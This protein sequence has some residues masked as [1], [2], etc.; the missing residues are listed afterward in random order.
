MLPSSCTIRCFT[1]LRCVRRSGRVLL[2]Y[3]RACSSVM[4]IMS[5]SLS[6]SLSTDFLG[7][8]SLPAHPSLSAAEFSLCD[9]LPCTSSCIVLS[10][11][12]RV[13]SFIPSFLIANSFILRCSSSRILFSSL[14]ICS[15]FFSAS[16]LFSSSS[17]FLTASNLFSSSLRF[18]SAFLSASFRLFSSSC[19]LLSSSRSFS[20]LRLSS[21]S[22]LFSS[23]FAFSLLC[24]SLALSLPLLSRLPC[25]LKV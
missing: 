11:S 7:N 3:D 9:L 24:S 6:C 13:F 14:R 1:T 21:S 20:F 4:D 25:S 12:A 2:R 8:S 22:I 16:L 17:L 15:A 10:C 5:W 18:S 19:C 23:S